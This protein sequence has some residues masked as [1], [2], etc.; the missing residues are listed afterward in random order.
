MDGFSNLSDVFKDNNHIE[1]LINLRLEMPDRLISN[2]EGKQNDTTCKEI[3][4]ILKDD[5]S[6]LLYWNK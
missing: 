5:D 2:F 1:E 6:D 4:H 3:E